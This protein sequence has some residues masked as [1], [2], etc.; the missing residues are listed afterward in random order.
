MQVELVDYFGSDESVVR[1]ARI[2]YGREKKDPVSDAFLIDYLIRHGHT[3]PFAH[4]AFTFRLHIP[5]YVARQIMRHHVGFAWNELSLRY[6]KAKDYMWVDERRVNGVDIMLDAYRYAQEAYENLIKL[7]NP[8]EVARAVLPLGIYTKLVVTANLRALFNL[9]E[10][11]LTKEAQEETRNVAQM[12]LD[13]VEELGDFHASL[14]AWR[15]WRQPTHTQEECISHVK[16][17]A[18]SA[19]E[20]DIKRYLRRLMDDGRCEPASA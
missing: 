6:T 19:T 14:T 18:P 1:A 20:K 4:T 9:W 13:A 17:L 5:I 15:F 10:Q 7:G 16:Q 11:R 12:M 3:S 8:P 2:S